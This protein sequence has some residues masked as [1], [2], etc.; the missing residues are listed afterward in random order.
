MLHTVTSRGFAIAA[1]AGLLV[2]DAGALEREPAPRAAVEPS[3]AQVADAPKRE[4]A[5]ARWRAQQKIG[6]VLAREVQR[7]QGVERELGALRQRVGENEAAIV[8]LRVQLQGEQEERRNA[9]LLAFALALVLSGLL[10][11]LALRRRSGQPLERASR[12]LDLHGGGAPAALPQ[13]PT[14]PDTAP[15]QVPSLVTGPAPDTEPRA[16]PVSAPS[17]VAD[18]RP[19]PRPSGAPRKVGAQELIEVHEKAEFFR[20][21]GETAHAVAVLDEHVHD[22]VQTGAL[23]WLHLLELYQAEGRDAE[24]DRLR[25][26]FRESF[27]VDVPE[28]QHGTAPGDPALERIVALWPSAEVMDVVEEALLPGA[29]PLGL[30]ACRELLLLHHMARDMANPEGTMAPRPVLRAFEPASTPAEAAPGE[31]ARER[32]MIPPAS[33]RLGVDIELDLEPAGAPATPREGPVLDF[34]L[35]A[36]EPPAGAAS[37]ARP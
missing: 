12:W 37:P 35:S 9:S 14:A 27:G 18:E 4:A 21:I 22:H 23:A 5:P 28:A 36:Y 19:R 25:A 11:W 7:L 1:C 2:C 15:P 8:Q 33:A 16:V 13:T 3:K 31:R 29:E 24:C 20:A 30:E 34:D 10:A 17:P 32:L 6:D 26:E